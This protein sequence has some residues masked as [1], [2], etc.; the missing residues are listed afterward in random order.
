MI[1]RVDNP[2][3]ELLEEIRQGLVHFNAPQF[4]HFD[5]QTIV[6]EQRDT[7]HALQ[8]GVIALVY[9]QVVL[10]RFL[11]VSEACRHQGLGSQLLSKVELL[12]REQGA[13]QLV[14]D[15]YS[16]QAPRF[17]QRHGFIEVGR[18]K[19]FPKP[20]CDKIFFSKTLLPPL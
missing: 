14:L 12:A 9:E 5:E 2:S 7:M 15:T 10:V 13:N 3:D 17:Y 11:W 6:F 19:N 20:G 16:F 8:G 18:Y 1:K 4:G